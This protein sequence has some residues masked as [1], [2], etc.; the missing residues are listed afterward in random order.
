MSTTFAQYLAEY[1][2]KVNT[3]FGANDTVSK[4]GVLALLQ[5]E[6]IKAHE[7]SVRYEYLGDDENGPPVWRLGTAIVLQDIQT[8]L[9]SIV[10]DGN[11]KLVPGA[12]KAYTLN[13]SIRV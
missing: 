4:A 10:T 8:H 12:K 3:G 11:A 2:S 9:N 7:V 1:R 13:P 5:A 6:Y